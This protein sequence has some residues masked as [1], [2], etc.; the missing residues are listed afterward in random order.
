M[1]IFFIYTTAEL[2]D[3]WPITKTAQVQG[4]NKNK[5]DNNKA[6]INNK[7]RQVFN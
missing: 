7:K 2:V 4:D 3:L 6:R 1:I 5:N